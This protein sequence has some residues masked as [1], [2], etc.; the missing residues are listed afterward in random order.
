[1]G[2][3]G[4]YFTWSNKHNDETFTNERLDRE[5]ANQQWFQFYAYFQMESLVARC[6][7]HRPLLIA[8]SH[9][10]AVSK[11][12]QRPFCYEASWSY[13]KE[14]SKQVETLWRNHSDNTQ[15]VLKVQQL[16]SHCSRRL[17]SWS[18]I[19]Q[20][21]YSSAITMKSATLKELQDRET[22]KYGRNQEF[23]A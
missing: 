18:A 6:S 21:D 8:C 22:Y 16:L 9:R 13:D 17:K 19:R 11:R 23:V 3:R 10:E 1:M 2:H 7:D 15:L 20:Q 14:C 12:K 4:D 5:V